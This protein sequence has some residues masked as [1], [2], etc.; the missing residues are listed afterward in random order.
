ML[1][2]C[3]PIFNNDCNKLVDDLYAQIKQQKVAIEII[4][5]DDKSNNNFRNTNKNLH[6]KCNYI[7]LDNNIG[8]AKFRNKFLD[9]CK[10]N[11]LL[12]LDNDAIIF[13]D[14][15]IEKYIT[16]INK[17]NCDVICGSTSFIAQSR[18]N[19]L[20]YKYCKFIEIK[21]L[22]SRKNR[23]YGS[24]MTNNFVIKKEVLLQ[25][26]FDENITT[27]GHEDTLFG[28]R[29][30]QQ[31][32]GILH[33]NNAVNC[34]ANDDNKAFIEKTKQ[35]IKNLAHITQDLDYNK[36]FIDDVKILSVYFKL[37]K[38]G[39]NYLIK[40][41][42]FILLRPLEVLL[43]KGYNNLYLYNFYKLLL[44]SDTNL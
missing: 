3:I 32:V 22:S 1:S 10:Y 33:I 9:Y 34:V 39:I 11:W 41:L 25:I 21:M 26:K 23:L 20:S 30:K 31:N 6:Q 35:A 19:Y 13:S 7:L 17:N 44:L 4:C 12:F 2:I 38:S 36:N 40:T 5:I 16:E 37:K 18:T 24:F 42:N 28:F 27:Y 8:R 15:F 14:N 29:L 43:I